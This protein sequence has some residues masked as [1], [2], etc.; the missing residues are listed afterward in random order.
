MLSLSVAFPPHQKGGL[1][2][3]ARGTIPQRDARGTHFCSTWSASARPSQ[4]TREAVAAY[5]T[6]ASK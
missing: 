5:G 1:F 6:D 4:I 2:Q 3:R